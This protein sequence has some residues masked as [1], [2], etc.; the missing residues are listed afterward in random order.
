MLSKS[1]KG[2]FVDADGG[3]LGMRWVK[4]VN[5]PLSARNLKG[6]LGKRGR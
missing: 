4:V 3:S 5:S 1:N 2:N 6:N